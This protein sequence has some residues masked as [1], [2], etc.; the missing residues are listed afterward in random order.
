MVA[1][2]AA[3]DG[4]FAETF[5]FVGQ[6]VGIVRFSA[7]WFGL[8]ASAGLPLSKTALLLTKPRASLLEDAKPV[9]TK[10]LNHVEALGNFKSRQAVECQLL[11]VAFGEMALVFGKQAFGNA[12]GGGKGFFAV[13]SDGSFL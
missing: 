10:S 11:E 12:L 2:A 1:F 8:L 4:V 7:A 5:V 9:F 13:K 6:H 3:D